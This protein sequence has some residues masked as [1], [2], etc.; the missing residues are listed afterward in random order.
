MDCLRSFTI[1]ID[2]ASTF[3][4]SQV[5][6]WTLGLQEFWSVD[7]TGL[8]TFRFQGFKNID[9]YGIDVI[10]NVNT[11]RAAA[12]G[13]CNVQDWSFEVLIEGQSPLVSGFVETSPTPYW[14]ISTGNVGSR[15]FSLS[16]NTNSV[17]LAEPIKSAQY[18]N[19]ERLNAQGDGGQTIG[20]ISLDYKLNF[21]VYYKY[22]GE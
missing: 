17:K 3:S 1:T 20:S 21:V 19:F 4:G 13:G 15:T 11:Q 16:K 10:G 14:N 6:T 2:Q 9:V 5:K 8:S 12:I 22:E 7:I 18:L